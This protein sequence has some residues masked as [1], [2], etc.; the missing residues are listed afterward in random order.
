MR[1]AR[2]PRRG[3]SPQTAGGAPA[4]AEARSCVRGSQE[5]RIAAQMDMRQ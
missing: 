2:T 3:A 5:T 1:F 4:G